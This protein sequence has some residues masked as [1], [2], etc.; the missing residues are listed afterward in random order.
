M[1]NKPLKIPAG[2]DATVQA[3]ISVW[4]R[5]VHW[6]I[7]AVCLGLFPTGW[8][9]PASHTGHLTQSA[10]SVFVHRS[11]AL[12]GAAVALLA[13]AGLWLWWRENPGLRPRAATFVHLGL[14]A[15]I[16]ALSATGAV[17]MY[18]YY[19]I[20]PAHQGL[21]YLME[22]LVTVHVI[23]ALWHHFVA[24]DATLTQMLSWRGSQRQN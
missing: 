24:R 1:R 19:G 8:A 12:A 6:A 3:P 4:R 9:I 21:T 10:W 15:A 13:L 16:L 20:A 2:P 14:F 5:G 23:A 7:V 11:H 17:A 22:V 18:L